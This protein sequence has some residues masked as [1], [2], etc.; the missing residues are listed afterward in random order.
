MKLLAWSNRKITLLVR[1]CERLE[2]LK[3]FCEPFA[4]RRSCQRSCLK[5]CNKPNYLNLNM[6]SAHR[7]TGL[8][9]E[10][11]DL[12]LSEDNVLRT[13]QRSIDPRQAQDEGPFRWVM[14]S[15]DL[16]KS[17][18]KLIFKSSIICFHLRQSLNFSLSSRSNRLKIRPLEN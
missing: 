7:L 11:F 10:D 2:S 13:S 3:A 14:G 17:R 6:F 18:F 5:D 8:R 12:R 15:F 4:E 1:F 16:N 9:V